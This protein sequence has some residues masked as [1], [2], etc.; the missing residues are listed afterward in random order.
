MVL[1]RLP[2]NSGWRRRWLYAEY[3]EPLQVK[4][5]NICIEGPLNIIRKKALAVGNDVVIKGNAIIDARAGVMI[6]DGAVLGKGCKIITVEK[7][8]GR[9]PRFDPVIIGRGASVA[10]GELAGPGSV[11]G[12]TEESKG[13]FSY[14][15]RLF[16]VVGTGR[17]GSKAIADMI[18]AHPEGECLHDAFSHLNVWS[19][20]LLYDKTAA[21]EV[22]NKLKLLYSVSDFARKKVH[23]QS[24]QKLSVFIPQLHELFPAAKFIWLIRRADLFVN[25]AYPR[26]WFRNEEFGYP[27]HDKEF[28]PAVA[29]PSL[30]HA[31]H[32][33]NGF[34][35]GV[36]S[37]REW[38]LM[39]AFERNC[40]YWA[41]WNQR[42]EN[43]LKKLPDHL[44]MQVKLEEL[45]AKSKEIQSFIGLP[46]R[47]F[48]VKKVNAAKYKKLTTENWTG[49]MKQLYRQ[50]CDETMKRWFG[51]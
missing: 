21:E 31:T 44:W 16:F 48:E 10:G 30:L 50:H 18:N 49:P 5:R 7:E 6:G 46:P 37:E 1:T 25:S 35:A 39:T 4:G 36:F 17:S 41:W 43:D 8:Q 42:I 24:D 19:C 40:W 45:S 32:R 33:P 9:S 20:Q 13:L 14:P 22:K 15:G 47:V 27:P 38:K 51:I 3:I 12:G 29:T 2:A 26:G 34:R 11:I 23:G 28:F